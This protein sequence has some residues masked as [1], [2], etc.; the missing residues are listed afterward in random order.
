M[1]QVRYLGVILGALV[2]LAACAESYGRDP[3]RTRGDGYE[4]TRTRGD[5]KEPT[6]TQNSGNDTAPLTQGYGKEPATLTPPLLEV[7]P[8]PS[9]QA[10]PLMALVDQAILETSQRKL[11]AGQHT[12]WQVVHGI[13]ALRWQCEIQYHGQDVSAIEWIFS[14]QT[15]DGQPLWQVT[16]YGGRG[17]PFTK[18]YAHEGHPQ[19]FLGYMSMAV[20]PLDYEIRADKGI[21]RIRDI[22]EDAKMSVT[23]GPEITWTLWALATY[24]DSDAEW[25]NAK[26]EHWS[27]ERLVY[28][29][30]K[31]EVTKGACGGCHGLFALAY[32][33]NLYLGSGNKLSG[34]WLDA[35]LKLRKYID[36]AQ[37]L[38]NPDGSFSS[39]NYK[40]P[41]YSTDFM[42]RTSTSGHQL[43]WL[44]IA[45]P[46]RQL[47]EPWVR[48]GVENI[49]RD[50][51]KHRNDP[52]D[53]GP[54]FH[55]LHSIILYKQR[56]QPGTMEPIR[57]SELTLAKRGRPKPPPPPRI[58]MP[59]E[60]PVR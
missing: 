18:P 53:C 51:I 4:P 57:N 33:K 27:I 50:L 49:A 24:L 29:Q 58:A 44:M 59:G 23:E 31:E 1:M 42:K 8:S 30:V 20:I 10:D 34:V 48:K 45:L 22:V 13:L 56:M 6:R 37:K 12:P 32:A 52:G 25:I 5:S 11:T 19:Q 47:K 14:G 9:R 16:P 43:E 35:D 38:Q 28:L 17:H 15:H 21:I 55:A 54:M 36:L 40:G 39:N 26:G 3:G 7:V 2:A 46:Q 41:G 60:S